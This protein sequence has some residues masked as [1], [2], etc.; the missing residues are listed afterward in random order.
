MSTYVAFL[1]SNNLVTQVVQAPDDGQDWV[2]IYA[3]RKNCTCVETAL[4]GSIREKYAKPGDTY[5]Q[6]ID[7]FMSPKP[8]LSWG[9]NSTTKKWEAPVEMPDDD[10]LV[11]EWDEGKKNWVII[12][13]V[14][15][16]GPIN[17]IDC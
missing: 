9:L 6:D 10:D 12:Y 5:Y 11:F 17:C 15:I 1:D 2:S 8:F 4:D 7:A 14:A 13:D 16:N 3:E